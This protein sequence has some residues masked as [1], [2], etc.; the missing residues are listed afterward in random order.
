MRRLIFYLAFGLLCLIAE[1]PV[2]AI[3]DTSD[4]KK[5]S[6]V[7]LDEIVLTGQ[8]D[9]K[10]MAEG[11]VT[12]ESKRLDVAPADLARTSDTAGL[13]RDIPGV[14]LQLNGGISSLPVIHGM[15]DDRL[16]IKV[17]GMDLISACP[18][19][20]NSP[21]S[22]IDPTNVGSVTVF[23]G[24]T[25]VSLGGDSI[26]GTILADSPAARIRRARERGS[27]QRAS[28]HFLSQQ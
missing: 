10:A 13:L 8:R 22:Y 4:D 1:A 2:W 26:G 6:V 14:S 24:I 12:L 7:T 5:G 18:N 21:L 11:P 15:A 16:R 28:R 25:P 17:D 20:M 9:A 27:A 19:H 3:D 23:A